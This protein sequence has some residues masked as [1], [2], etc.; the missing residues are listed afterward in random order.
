[1][2]NVPK[3][4]Y[5]ETHD[6]QA[7]VLEVVHEASL[8]LKNSVYI[9]LLIYPGKPLVCHKTHKTLY[10]VVYYVEKIP[11]I[12]EVSLKHVIKMKHRLNN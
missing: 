3:V 10:A 1:M 5:S 6:K 7:C 12:T 8:E 4:V 2:E 9:G 11:F